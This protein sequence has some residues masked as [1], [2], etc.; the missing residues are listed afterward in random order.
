MA[1]LVTRPH[2]DD[3]ATGSA[4]RARGFEVL[5][6]PML[7]FEPVAFYDD[8]DV[9]YG[10]VAVPPPRGAR[11]PRAGPH[12]R[13]RNFGTGDPAMLHLRRGGLGRPRRRGHAGHGGGLS[14]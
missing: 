1:V 8:A 6:A 14:G 2:P 10:V 7:R 13:R 4:L 3:E 5:L 9:P 12:R 11:V